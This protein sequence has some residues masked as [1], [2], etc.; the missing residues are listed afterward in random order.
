MNPSLKKFPRNVHVEPNEEFNICIQGVDDVSWQRLEPLF[1]TIIATAREMVSSSSMVTFPLVR[2]GQIIGY[3]CGPFLPAGTIRFIW[4]RENIEYGRFDTEFDGD[5]TFGVPHHEV[6]RRVASWMDASLPFVSLYQTLFTRITRRLKHGSVISI[7]RLVTDPTLI[8]ELL[9]EDANGLG[10]SPTQVDR[11]LLTLGS[12]PK[13]VLLQCWISA[14][15]KVAQRKKWSRRLATDAESPQLIP[16]AHW[17]GYR[18]DTDNESLRKVAENLSSDDVAHLMRH[19]FIP[20]ESLIILLRHAGS[21][22]KIAA[23]AHENCP[24]G[25]LMAM[26]IDE[27]STVRNCVVGSPR[28]TPEILGVVGQ[29]ADEF[30]FDRLAKHPLTPPEIL[31]MLAF[32]SNFTTRYHA[33][34]SLAKIT[35]IIRLSDWVRDNLG[36][37]SSRYLTLVNDILA[38]GEDPSWLVPAGRFLKKVYFDNATMLYKALVMVRRHF[39]TIINANIGALESASLEK[40]ADLLRRLPPSPR[41]RMLYSI[42][43]QR[44]AILL[45][46]LTGSIRDSRVHILNEIISAHAQKRRP[47][48]EGVAA[49][50]DRS[51]DRNCQHLLKASHAAAAPVSHPSWFVSLQQRTLQYGEDYTLKGATDGY[52]LRSWGQILRNCLRIE[53]IESLFSRLRMELYLGVF[54]SKN[55]LKYLVR[56]GQGGSVY[57]A[58]GVMNQ[59]IDPDLLADLNN[60]ISKEQALC[61]KNASQIK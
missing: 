54:D 33:A 42:L 23:I 37:N 55:K 38:K 34:K 7:D 18:H 61:R 14:F 45:E 27:C 8:Y 29:F 17:L 26:A 52:Q 41:I 53:S 1:Q 44:D 31:A 39:T 2:I 20:E 36:F 19:S 51:V 5:E 30:T 4:T 58:Y 46:R 57:E 59:D 43:R 6:A 47:S 10:Y 12:T 21:H 48:L 16:I 49:A 15:T 35:G 9:R 28:V 22:A 3:P 50:L 11:V 13:K 32:D 25:L 56:M 24:A 60:L 40:I